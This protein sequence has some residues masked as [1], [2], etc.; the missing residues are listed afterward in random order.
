MNIRN[1]IALIMGGVS[2]LALLFGMFTEY[3][4]IRQTS[5]TAEKNYADTVALLTRWEIQQKLDAL[6]FTTRDYAEWDRSWNFIEAPEDPARNME[7][8]VSDAILKRNRFGLVAICRKDGTLLLGKRLDLKT[9]VRQEIPR[10]MENLIRGWAQFGVWQKPFRGFARLDGE[11]WALASSP[12]TPSDRSAPANGFLMFG[13]PAEQILKEINLSPVSVLMSR[14]ALRVLDSRGTSGEQNISALTFPEPAFPYAV[15]PAESGEGRMRVDITLYGFDGTPIALVS[16]VT[17]GVFYKTSET[18][19]NQALMGFVLVGLL[20]TALL[21]GV[22]TRIV[23]LPV[24]ELSRFLSG[25]DL[26]ARNLPR[27]YLKNNDETGQLA[28]AINRML[29]TLESAQDRERK[30]RERLQKSEERFRAF[31]ENMVNG[32][33]LHEMIFDASG[34]PKDYRFLEVND[35]FERLT[36]LR[37]DLVV[38]KTILEV[39]PN[40]DPFWIRFYGDVVRTRK[41]A[42]IVR[43]SLVLGRHYEVRAFSPEPGQFVALFADVTERVLQ[44]KQRNLLL[45]LTDRLNRAHSRDDILDALHGCFREAFGACVAEF[46]IEGADMALIRGKDNAAGGSLGALA[47][48]IFN[49]GELHVFEDSLPD[50]RKG[51]SAAY[52]CSGFA[53]KQ[54]FGLLAEELYQWNAWGKNLFLTSCGMAETTLARVL[55]EERLRRRLELEALSTAAS[56]RYMH[57]D[58]EEIREQISAVIEDIGRYCEAER[59]TLLLGIEPRSG[60][61]SEVF[62]WASNAGEYAAGH[63]DKPNLR[64]LPWLFGQLAMGEVVLLDGLDSLPLAAVEERS[65]MKA[66]GWGSRSVRVIPLMSGP[67]VG[68]A[69]ILVGAASSR[70]AWL[71]EDIPQ[72]RIIGDLTMMAWQRARN[73]QALQK[74]IH[75]LTAPDLGETEYPLELLFSPDDLQELQ[76][77]FARIHGVFSVMLDREGN[78]FTRPTVASEAAALDPNACVK[79]LRRVIILEAGRSGGAAKPQFRLSRSLNGLFWLSPL[80]AGDHLL[81]FWVIGFPE[82][83]VDYQV[84]PDGA[85]GSDWLAVEVLSESHQ[86][87]CRL[88]SLLS[89]R[90]SSLAM[91]NIRQAYL[92]TQI[93]ESEYLQRRLFHSVEQAGEGMLFCDEKGTVLYANTAARRMFNNLFTDIEEEKFH[94]KLLP[95]AHV[96]CPV[97]PEQWFTERR[98]VKGELDFAGEDG[99]RRYV[100]FSLSPVSTGTGKHYDWMVVCQDISHVKRLEDQLIQSRKMEAIGNLA[101]GVAHDFNNLL[102]VISGYAEIL[103]TELPER[104]ENRSLAQEIA[105]AAHRATSLTRQL[106]TFSRQQPMQAR[107]LDINQTVTQLL[108]MLKRVLGEHIALEFDA[109]E[110]LPQVMADPSHMD[111]VL[112]NLCVNARDAMPEG[113]RLRIKTELVEFRQEYRTTHLETLPRGRYVS[114]SVSDTGSGIPADILPRIFEPFFTT[115]EL[116]RGT[117]LGLATVY[118]IVSRHQGAVDVLS[119]P[120]QGTTMRIYL[121]ALEEQHPEEATEA[122]KKL[123]SELEL[124]LR[125]KR[126]LLAEDEAA[127]RGMTARFL[128]SAGVQVVEAED[129]EK[130]LERFHESPESF[131]ALILDVIMPGRNG[132]DVYN[133][134]RE[135]RPEIPVIFCTGYSIDMINQATVSHDRSSRLLNKPYGAAD[136]LRILANLLNGGTS[137]T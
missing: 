22:L 82:S 69:L 136:L 134:V 87:I 131:D 35:A 70:G 83:Q 104:S 113:G 9:G 31:F 36:G 116:G 4:I 18:V 8:E 97:T 51:A 21:Y 72:L 101:S 56:I 119:T 26:S 58:P 105:E 2:I 61:V 48:R 100:T 6:S 29:D 125:G 47:E 20:L 79:Q 76:D 108:K 112:I 23:S 25:L 74:R 32:A 127:V 132:R 33:A 40:L 42:E 66:Q 93:S 137:R 126:V 107:P 73:A 85:A 110:H 14:L 111:Q 24:G 30:E 68:G 59:L 49:A 19:L 103:A 37:R 55:S 115:K 54:I 46:Y 86:Q 106:L 60:R 7:P 135:T 130:A 89:D 92:I 128:R 109:G 122:V 13:Q 90:L 12:V 64:E 65:M 99:H 77:A 84:I 39:H 10:D 41:P 81:G 124:Q 78:A 44:E 5:A 88:M 123:E 15:T 120:G 94:P 117:G 53:E 133:A 16:T 63:T 11:L 96:R 17:P 27:V 121:P 102:Q 28:A 50:G 71:R 62:R 67:D 34:E 98:I 1:K 80:N 114:I 129:G 75:M 3:Y 57:G 38:G 52:L 91:Q 45:T 43:E 95:D 118:G